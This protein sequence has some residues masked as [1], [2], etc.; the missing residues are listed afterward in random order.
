[1]FKFSV[2]KN[3]SLEIIKS[4]M[5]MLNIKKNSICVTKELQKHIDTFDGEDED[6]CF[7]L[8]NIIE[9]KH[10][11]A[12]VELYIDKTSNNT[13][14]VDHYTEI[15]ENAE[16]CDYERSSYITIYDIKIDEAINMKA[17]LY[18][19]E[20][21]SDISYPSFTYD[22]VL[23]CWVIKDSFWGATNGVD[24]NG[25]ISILDFSDYFC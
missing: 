12:F 6:E 20:Y 16:K 13:N 19:T 22:E 1:M 3:K 25:L 15:I 17:Y 10:K 2:D 18:G 7:K 21:G 23:Q 9:Y 4:I 8:D 11:L 24:Y 14:I 5:E